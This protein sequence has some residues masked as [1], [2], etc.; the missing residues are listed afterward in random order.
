MGTSIIPPAFTP[1][2]AS[3]AALYSGFGVKGRM[4]EPERQVFYFMR[5]DGSANTFTPQELR[6]TNWWRALPS[7]IALSIASMLE[8]SGGVQ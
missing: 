8:R 6:S 7:D 4:S 5:E 2:D 3:T 1:E